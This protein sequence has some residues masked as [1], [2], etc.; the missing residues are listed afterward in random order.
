MVTLGQAQ[1]IASSLIA[2]SPA[3]NPQ[4]VAFRNGQVFISPTPLG[5]KGSEAASLPAGTFSNG[6]VVSVALF[7]AANSSASCATSSLTPAATPALS[8]ALHA[9]AVNSVGVGVRGAL[10]AYRADPFPGE[11]SNLV[12]AT[13]ALTGG[14]NDA[15]CTF[16]FSSPGRAPSGAVEV[17]SLQTGKCATVAGWS[18]QDTPGDVE[19]RCS[20]LGGSAGFVEGDRP[21]AL[22]SSGVCGAAGGLVLAVGSFLDDGHP[23][24]LAFVQPTACDP[25][26][27][28]SDWRLCFDPLAV[29]LPL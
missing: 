20:A 11:A 1:M 25:D 29:S 2:F 15:Y 13:E 28:G 22:R 7:E 26:G 12:F 10:A 6:D 14:G 5:F 27:D 9:A 16:A 24:G 21:L 19:V 4:S 3:L 23:L 8:F 18:C 17:A